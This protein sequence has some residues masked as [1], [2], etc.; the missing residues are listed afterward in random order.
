M[1]EHKRQR[2]ARH[3]LRRAKRPLEE[4]AAAVED[5]AEQLESAYLDLGDEWRGADGRASGSWR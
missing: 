5:V 2:C 1:E 4:F 3:L